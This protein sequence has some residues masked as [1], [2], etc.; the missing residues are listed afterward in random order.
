M[1]GAIATA[2]TGT[3]DIPDDDAARQG[4][5]DDAGKGWSP[6]WDILGIQQPDWWGKS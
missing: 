2:A 1:P 4:W 5:P 3:S 6:P